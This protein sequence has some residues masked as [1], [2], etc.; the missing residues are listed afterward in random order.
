MK[1]MFQFEHDGNP[2]N[3]EDLYKP[4][5]RKE[6]EEAGFGRW[7]PAADYGDQDQGGHDTN[8]R[9]RHP[10]AKAQKTS[11]SSTWKGSSQQ[12]WGTSTWKKSQGWK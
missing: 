10:K 11:E 9:S 4:M 12:S 5:T 1:T 3:R 6:R 7:L 8:Y 2:E